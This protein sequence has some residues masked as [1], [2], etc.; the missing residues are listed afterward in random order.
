M[1]HLEASAGVTSVVSLVI[2][3]LA[4]RGVPGSA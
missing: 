4:L 1:G 2:T 3:L